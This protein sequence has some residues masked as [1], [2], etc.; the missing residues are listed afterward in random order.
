MAPMDM[1]AQLG[2]GK[3]VQFAV[4]TLVELLFSARNGCNFVSII[5]AVFIEAVTPA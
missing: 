1:L 2:S 4:G 3:L 5:S